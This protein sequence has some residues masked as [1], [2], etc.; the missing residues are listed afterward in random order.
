VCAQAADCDSFGGSGDGKCGGRFI[1]FEPPLTAANVCTALADV[2]VP[3]SQR[4]TGNK[5]G[6]KMLRLL[7]HTSAGGTTGRDSDSLTLTCKP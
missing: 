2:R 6:R 1:A 3:V 4:A 5:P 7:T